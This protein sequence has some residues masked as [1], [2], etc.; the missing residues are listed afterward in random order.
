MPSQKIL[1]QGA[2]AKII[3]QEN[4]VIKDRISKSYRHPELDN[5]IIKSRTRKEIKLLTKASQIINCPKPQ[6]TDKF[7]QIKIPFIQGKKLSEHLDRF[8]SKEQYKICKKIGEQI[9]KLHDSD[10]IHGDLTTSNMILVKD[11]KKKRRSIKNKS[12]TINASG[13]VARGDG[14]GNKPNNSKIYFIDFGLGFQ[15]SRIEDKAVDLHLLKQALEAK[16]YKN[17]EKLFQEVVK[18]YSK[19]K[20]NKKVLEQLKKVESRGRYKH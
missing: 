4:F 1:I 12:L 18:G 7:N 14:G 2:E 10:I 3:K 16:H 8:P 19:S 9:A 11:N 15:S 6:E 5:K 20:N 17:W 13:R